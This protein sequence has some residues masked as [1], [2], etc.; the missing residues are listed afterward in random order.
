MFSIAYHYK[1]GGPGAPI[2][3]L[4]EEN[5]N[6]AAVTVRED[7]RITLRTLSEILKISL[8]STHTLV[9][10]KLNMRRVEFQDC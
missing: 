9:T 8:G 6:T 10:E 7:R 4:K 2:S 3:A 5:S 1:E